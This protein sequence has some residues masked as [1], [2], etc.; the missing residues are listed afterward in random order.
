MHDLSRRFVE[1]ADGA[2]LE[3]AGPEMASTREGDSA[4]SRRQALTEALSRVPR[5]RLARLPTPLIEAPRLSAALRGPRIWIKREDLVGLGIGGSKYRILEFTLGHALANRADVLIAGG[6]AQSNHPQQVVCAAS[7]VGLPVVVL[8]GGAEGHVGW[9]GNMLLQGLG[10]AEIR[11]L[12]AAG[13]D[14]LRLAQEALAAELRERGRRPAIVTLT[15]E[16]HV[17]GV[18]AYLNYMIELTQQLEE[19][20]IEPAAVYI[21]SAGPSY[22]G[23]ALGAMALG[24]AF[25]VIGVSP[26]G[27]AVVNSRTVAELMTTAID[28]LQ[29]EVALDVQRIRITDAY[30]GAGH[31]IT[32]PEAVAAIKLAASS[33]GIF[34]D[35]VYSGKAMAGLIDHVNKRELLPN[36]TVVFVHTGGVPSL[37]AYSDEVMPEPYSIVEAV[38]IEPGHRVQTN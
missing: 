16:A 13:F 21:G 18:M 38:T 9:T 22:A 8:L 4:A 2:R 24:V 26:L 30:L 12:P 17:F 7:Q 20:G 15:R 1:G 33:E 31:G 34:L 36:Q 29:I 5:V 3:E 19:L 6:M 11:V 32:T 27:S 37:F 10:G 28:E 14:E 23:M 35:P 25:D